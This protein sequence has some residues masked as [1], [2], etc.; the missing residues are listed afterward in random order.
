[1]VSEGFA[2]ATA[3][4]SYGHSDDDE[5]EIRRL[6]EKLDSAYKRHRGEALASFFDRT[7]KHKIEWGEEWRSKISTTIFGTTFFIPVI[8]P[9]YL[10]SSMCRDEFDEFVEK[11]KTSDL[12]EL[13]MPILW[14]P[15][16]PE[17]VDEQRIFDAAKARQ[18]VDWTTIR[19]L[20]ESTSD[21]RRLIDEMGERL[22]NAARKVAKKPEVLVEA[23]S[24][25]NSGDDA[26][27]CVDGTEATSL[28][29]PPGLLEL[30]A[31]TEELG[32]LMQTHMQA[33]YAA[34]AAAARHSRSIRG[35]GTAS[36]TIDPL[37]PNASAGQRIVFYKK[38]AEEIT[39][40]AEE[41]ER[42]AQKL[43]ETA[44]LRN[45]T[46]FNIADILKDPQ[47]PG[48]A[49]YDQY[50]DHLLYE[51]L[52]VRD[53]LGALAMLVSDMSQLARLSR[54]LRGPVAAIE[55]GFDSMG[56][57]S[58]LVNGWIGTFWPD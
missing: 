3:F 1:M 19:K 44:R 18:W 36:T 31:E 43:E 24:G 5:G 53:R 42:E 15:V 6:K 28:E 40:Y 26:D 9:S 32:S 12:E 54:D 13:I 37:Q 20:D 49:D 7:G 25:S 51:L 4:W 22:A 8:S 48:A 21:H 10:K 41:F 52:G 38:V 34:L 30:F 50:L 55:R 39:P 35:T 14:V 17:T 23:E 47:S 2:T 27:E 58:Q 46:I 56:A 11:A 33:A 16:Y 57:A 29:E 45:R